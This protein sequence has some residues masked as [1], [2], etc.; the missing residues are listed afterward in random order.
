MRAQPLG[1]PAEA[2]LRKLNSMLRGFA[3]H[4]RHVVAKR[5]FSYIDRAVRRCVSQWLKRQHSNKTP[6]WIKRRYFVVQGPRRV[7]SAPAAGGGRLA[8]FRLSDLP[9]V[10]HVKVQSQATPFD[11]Y[12]EKYFEQRR[13]QQ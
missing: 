1:A 6:A 7:L 8:L 12:Y 5:T 3:L 13:R 9:I 2:L 11:L 4:G 10:R